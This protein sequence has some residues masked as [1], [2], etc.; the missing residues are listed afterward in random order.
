[1]RN[2]PG[3]AGAAPVRGKRTAVPGRQIGPISRQT[4]GSVVNP[5]FEDIRLSR[6]T[7]KKGRR[8]SFTVCLCSAR[9]ALFP[10]SES[11]LGT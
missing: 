11:K 3:K 5:F 4:G 7:Q 6:L 10:E 2:G 1:M 9:N 8:L